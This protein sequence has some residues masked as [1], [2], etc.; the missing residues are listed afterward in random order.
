[1]VGS[2]EIS[3]CIND[4]VAIGSGEDDLH[5]SGK[6]VNH[7]LFMLPLLYHDYFHR[8]PIL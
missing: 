3:S 2:E 4:G 6:E 5:I 7:V 1:M 8:L